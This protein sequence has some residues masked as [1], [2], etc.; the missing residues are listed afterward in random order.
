M[1][2]VLE[3]SLPLLK[4]AFPEAKFLTAAYPGSVCYD[5]YNE[6]GIQIGTWDASHEIVVSR[7][8]VIEI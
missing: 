6:R 3:N 2:F 4:E 7:L 8:E 5:V 1:Y